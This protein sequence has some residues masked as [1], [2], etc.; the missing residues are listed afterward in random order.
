MDIHYSREQLA[1]FMKYINPVALAA[2]CGIHS[3]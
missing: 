1:L 2:D 3:Q